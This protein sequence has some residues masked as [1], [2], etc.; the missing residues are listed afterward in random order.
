MTNMRLPKPENLFRSYIQYHKHT[1]TQPKINH[2]AERLLEKKNQV[3]S[4]FK[5]LHYLSLS[6]C[7]VKADT[8]AQLG[9]LPISLPMGTSGP[10]Q[11]TLNS[12]EY[13]GYS[14]PSGIE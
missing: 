5:C 11:V 8:P 1:S 7:Q 2:A 10:A 4:L 12:K 14:D 13:P 3:L 6:Q 9:Y